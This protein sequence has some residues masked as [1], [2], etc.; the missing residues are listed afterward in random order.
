VCEGRKCTQPPTYKSTRKSQTDIYSMSST[1][2]FNIP[3]TINTQPYIQKRKG[4]INIQ[5]ITLSFTYSI[6]LAWLSK[7]P[8]C[9]CHLSQP[10]SRRRRR[11][12]KKIKLSLKKIEKEVTTI[13]YYEKLWKNR[14]KNKASLWKPNFGS[15]CRLREG[16]VLAP[17]Q[18][19]S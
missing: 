9:S 5:K 6:K 16:K 4:N 2:G 8:Q 12:E 10:K 13:V 1:L 17:L 19:R 18:S 3:T 15:R 14:K 7:S 11:S